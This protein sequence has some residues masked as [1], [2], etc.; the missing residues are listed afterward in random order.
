MDQQSELAKVKG[1]IRALAAKTVERG[2]SEAE[3]MAAAAK[4]GE[5]LE[6]Y[7]L[8]MSEVEL[9]EEACVQ[10]R[11]T[12]P[13]PGRLAL[14]WL[15]PSVLRLCECRGWTDGRQDF[16]LFG[17]EPDVQMA[18]YLLRVIE[19]AL[20]W[21]EAQYR[22]GPAYRANP[23]PGQAVLRSFRYGFADRVAKRLDAMVGER[24]AAAER[25]R[26]AAPAGTALVLAKARKVD[27]G[28]RGLGIRLR[29]VT[30]SATVRDRGAYGHGAAA[31]GRVG[32][33]RPVGAGPG[34]KGLK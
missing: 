3:A 31:G 12:A 18:E 34:T 32:L 29:T 13:G 24:Q 15:F 14:R 17:L 19:G 30:S 7:G 21:E 25:R 16:V 6:V 9:R 27:E 11:V 2:C 10:A 1:R 5:L 4:V 8:S 23:L 33:G 26:A 22:R 20:A 28:M